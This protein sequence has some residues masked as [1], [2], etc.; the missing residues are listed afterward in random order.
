MI[1][2]VLTNY[3]KKFGKSMTEKEAQAIVKENGS[4]VKGLHYE[5]LWVYEHSSKR[6]PKINVKASR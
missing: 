3:G 1:A 6:N 5:R 2:A 4:I